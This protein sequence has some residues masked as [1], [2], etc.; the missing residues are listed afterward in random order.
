MNYQRL[1]LAAIAALITFFAWGFLT[2]GWLI[3][4][5]FA[6]SASLYRTS[7]LQMKYAFRFSICPGGVVGC[8]CDLRTLVRRYVR[9]CER[10]TVRLLNG[11][12][13]RMHPS[14][15]QSCNHEHECEARLGNRNKQCARLGTCRTRHRSG[16]QAANVL[17]CPRW[18][19]TQRTSTQRLKHSHDTNHSYQGF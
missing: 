17:N 16:L 19:P 8:G 13:R 14:D 4:K 6:A 1:V 18:D 7:D 10:T 3:R 12:I 15:F 9:R 11:S 5:D 2:E